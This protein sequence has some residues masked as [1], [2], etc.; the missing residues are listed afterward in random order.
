MRIEEEEKKD[1]YVLEV[2]R[3]RVEDFAIW[4]AAAAL[5]V[6]QW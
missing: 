2:L 1:E 6:A 4:G 3:A 5:A